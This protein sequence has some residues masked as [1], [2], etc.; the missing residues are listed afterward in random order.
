MVILRGE[1]GWMHLKILEF[2]NRLANPR[3]WSLQPLSSRWL[4]HGK[5]GCAPADAGQAALER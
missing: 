4:S 3:L 1:E 2:P 5:A